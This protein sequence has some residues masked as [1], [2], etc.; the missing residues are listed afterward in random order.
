[1][2]GFWLLRLLLQWSYYDPEVRRKNRVL[3]AMYVR[4]WLSDPFRMGDTSHPR[5]KEGSCFGES[6]RVLRW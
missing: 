6:I 4:H 3:D 1:M 2:G 5:L